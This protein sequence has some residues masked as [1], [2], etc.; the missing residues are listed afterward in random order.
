VGLT[1]SAWSKVTYLVGGHVLRIEALSHTCSTDFSANSTNHYL[2]TTSDAV[3]ANETAFLEQH[4]IDV[5]LIDGLHTYGQVVRD[6]ENTLRYLRDDGVI[7]LHDCNPALAVIGRP[8]ASY[9][10]FLAQ[11]KGPL[12]IGVWSGDVSGV[13]CRDQSTVGERAV[14]QRPD[15]WCQQ[16]GVFER[17]MLPVEVHQGVAYDDRAAVRGA[18]QLGDVG[19]LSAAGFGGGGL[20]C[21]PGLIHRGRPWR[22]ASRRVI[23]VAGQA[24]RHRCLR[25]RD[26]P[27]HQHLGTSAAQLLH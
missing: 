27:E 24:D 9:A 16:P 4:G 25:I 11:Q 18:E 14:G 23:E 3:F 1:L 10:D 15:Y 22:R 21:D 8:A 5:A 26:R 19:V 2:E 7:F 13:P 20:G 6:V 12:V 17:Q